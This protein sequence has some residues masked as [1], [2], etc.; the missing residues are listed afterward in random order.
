MELDPKQE[1]GELIDTVGDYVNTR[2][3]I[4]KLKAIK[5]SSD[6]L[7]SIVSYSILLVVGAICFL[8]LNIALG[9]YL[10]EV[11]GETYYGFLAVS[12]FYLLIILLLWALRKKLFKLPIANAL[13]KKLMD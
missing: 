12:G 5:S 9:Y 11:F 4:F 10:G 6:I 8:L 13:I 1:A 7:S 3:S 2:L